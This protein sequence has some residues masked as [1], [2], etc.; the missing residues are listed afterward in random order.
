M[1]AETEAL[2]LDKVQ[3]EE[4]VPCKEDYGQTCPVLHKFAI[5]TSSYVTLTRTPCV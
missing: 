1:D 3:R 2:C 4:M 5:L